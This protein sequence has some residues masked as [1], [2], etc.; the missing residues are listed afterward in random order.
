MAN[1]TFGSTPSQQAQEADSRSVLITS[2]VV[3][4]IVIGALYYWYRSMNQ[5]TTMPPSP[6]PSPTASQNDASLNTLESDINATQ[7]T[8]LDAEMNDIG[9]E[10]K[11]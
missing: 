9:K 10:I 2:I 8:S 3:I 1:N 5:P 7:T 6:S 11:K 4:L